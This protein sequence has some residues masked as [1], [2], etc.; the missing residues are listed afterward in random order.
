MVLSDAGDDTE[1]QKKPAADDEC[2]AKE[3]FY[4]FGTV[5]EYICFACAKKKAAA[6]RG[7]LNHDLHVAQIDAAIVGQ[8]FCG[9]RLPE[10]ERPMEAP[11]ALLPRGR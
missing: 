2:F 3:H 4:R 5:G 9:Q 8:P 7:R 10:E 11:Q 1:L 6:F